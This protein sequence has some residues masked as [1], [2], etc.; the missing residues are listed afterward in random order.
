[1][2]NSGNNSGEPFHASH[3]FLT[4]WLKEGLNWDGMIVTDWA[5]IENLYS[6]DH[7]AAS[8]KERKTWLVSCQSL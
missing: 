3:K 5:D 7:V 4:E 6:R 8:K 1:M 2:V